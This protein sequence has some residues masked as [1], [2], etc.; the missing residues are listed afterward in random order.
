MY[1]L[2][3]SKFPMEVFASNTK[4][5]HFCTKLTS[6]GFKRFH[7]IKLPDSSGIELATDRHWFRSLMLI[8]LC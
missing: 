8:Q 1:K 3:N 2:E 7:Q 5:S 4:I 6:R